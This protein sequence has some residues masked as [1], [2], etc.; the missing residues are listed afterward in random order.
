MPRDRSRLFAIWAEGLERELALAV[1]GGVG[2][3]ARRALAAVGK[4]N[5]GEP[6]ARLTIHQH[7]AGH[8]KRG[9]AGFTGTAGCSHKNGQ[10][11]G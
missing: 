5:H 3:N 9:R 1:G 2:R 4:E 8:R 7:L 6:G 11:Q 10:T